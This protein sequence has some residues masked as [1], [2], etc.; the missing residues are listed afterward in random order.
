MKV[1]RGRLL[2]MASP[3]RMDLG[4]APAKREGFSANLPEGKVSCGFPDPIPGRCVSRTCIPGKQEREADRA[5]RCSPCGEATWCGRDKLASSPR[6]T[7]MQ[8]SDS[9][10]ATGGER[11]FSVADSERF[12]SLAPYWDPVRL[13]ES[14]SAKP[15]VVE[16]PLSPSPSNAAKILKLGPEETVLVPVQSEF[17]V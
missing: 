17:R 6:M 7:R 10:S 3:S 9:K 1:E 16:M 12:L 13:S 5:I 8:H 11:T 14:D 2:P 4:M 15:G